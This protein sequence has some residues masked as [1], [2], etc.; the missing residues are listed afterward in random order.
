MGNS[1][2][3]KCGFDITDYKDILP[4]YEDYKKSDYCLN[5]DEYQKGN[6]DNCIWNKY[7]PQLGETD[8]LEFRER[9]IRRILKTGVYACVSEEIVWIPPPLY[10]QLQYT[11]VNGQDPEFRLKRLMNCYF[12]IRARN[13]PNCKGSF[14]VKNRQDGETTYSMCEAFWQTFDMEDGQI[15]INSKTREDAQNPCWKTMQSIYMGMPSWLF[16]TFFGDCITNGR[17]IAES[18][19][20]LRFADDN[21]NIS[22]KNVQLAYYPT[23]YNSLDGK[24]SVRK[25]IGDEI[26]KWLGCNFGDW[27]N[28]ASKFIIP[29]FKRAGMF[30]LFSSPPEKDSQSYRDGY[31]VWINSDPKDR[32]ET[33]TTISRI[34]RYHSNPLHG[35]EGAYDKFGDADPQRI[36]DHIMKERKRQPKSKLLEEVRGFPLNEEEIWGSMETSDFWDNQKGIEQRK[37]YLLGARFKN[38]ETKEPIAVY[39]NLEWKDGLRDS[40][41]EFRQSE[42]EDFDVG[43][44]RF[45]FSFMP[46]NREALPNIFVPPHYIENVM[47]IDSVDKRYPGKRHSNVAMVNYKFRDLY[48]TG[49]VKCPTMLYSNRPIPVEIAFEDAIKAMV[50]NRALV[51]VESLNLNIVNWMEDRGYMKWVLSKRGEA[52][53]SLRK[54]DAPSGKSAFIDEIVGLINSITNVPLNE[55]GTYHLLNMWHKELLQDISVFN[56]KD[57]HANDCSMAFGQ[58][59]LGALKILHEKKREPS[60]I[61]TGVLDYLL[62]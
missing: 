62:N 34:E 16:N 52:K 43:D 8:S 25:A 30:D 27:L 40:V 3:F 55:E 60:S 9:E 37:V 56:K 50:F 1:K 31:E 47:G 33:G 2:I 6:L 44:A 53:D 46:Q 22:A 38:E 35:I 11:N 23:V 51:Q 42:K 5:M 48:N 20:F 24:N 29:G 54:G 19:K 15:T 58:S 17:N 28:N 18:I 12:R 10:F 36:Y 59:L 14:I 49:I 4:S 39:G 41:P 13:N 61:N 7:K 57:T 26:L 32:D 45:S 21:K